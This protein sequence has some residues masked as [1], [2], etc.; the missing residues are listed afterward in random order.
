VEMLDGVLNQYFVFIMQGY[1]SEEGACRTGR[2]VNYLRLIQ[3]LVKEVLSLAHIFT[4][5]AGGEIIKTA[6]Y[7]ALA[8]T[9]V[10]TPVTSIS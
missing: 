4:F 5:T 7:N 3:C 6:A 2:T 8:L 1:S 10:H 9:S